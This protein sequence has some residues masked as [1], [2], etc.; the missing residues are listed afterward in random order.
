MYILTS[1]ENQKILWLPFNKWSSTIFY[2]QRMAISQDRETPVV[3]SCSKVEDK[4]VNGIAR[5]TW[6]QDKWNE[7]N[8][9]KEYDDDGNLVGIWCDFFKENIP[10][11]KPDE[12][13]TSI[14]SIITYSGNNANVRI[15]GSYKKLT[16]KFYDDEGEIEFQTGSWKFTVNDADVSALIETVT[17]TEDESLSS[18]QIK[19][20]FTGDDSYIGKNLVV[21]YISENDIES[22]VTLNLLGL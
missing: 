9:Y 13:T 22:S 12:P 5:Y 1:P 2:D 20:K 11:E 19:I 21:S 16:V 6:K 10:P 17:P 14:Y 3:W 4:N 7:H 18:N 8:D 15:N